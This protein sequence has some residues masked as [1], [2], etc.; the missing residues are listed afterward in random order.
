MEQVSLSLAEGDTFLDRYR[1]ERVLG[2]GGM[3]KVY[4]ASDLMLS[5]FKIALKTLHS[6]LCREPK[7]KQRFLREVQLN[8]MLNHPNV[9]KIFDIGHIGDALY[10]TMEFVKGKTLKERLQESKLSVQEIVSILKEICKGLIAVHN[11]NIIHRDLKPGN[12]L[13]SDSG[14]VKIADFGVARPGV[15][16]LTAHDE[17]IGCAPYIA[18]EV[19]IGRNVSAAADIY[20]LG[21]MAYEMLVGEL[22]FDGDSPAD[23]MR[24]HLES[25][26]Y[27]LREIDP[28]TPEWLENLTLM[29][30][31]KD[32]SKRP[33]SAKEILDTL[34]SG[35]A[36]IENSNHRREPSTGS[37]DEDLLRH[38]RQAEAAV[39]LESEEQIAPSTP[40]ERRAR[41]LPDWEGEKKR[42]IAPPE[43][44]SP[45][46]ESAL[47][48][49]KLF[50]V[51]RADNF[52]TKV[53]TRSGSYDQ[54]NDR[55]AP[56]DNR[57]F[58]SA[59]RY[60]LLFAV[61]IVSVVLV[62]ALTADYATKLIS[63]IAQPFP[64]GFSLVLTSILESLLITPL[65]AAP[66]T[67]VSCLSN[68]KTKL[69]RAF[70][71]GWPRS[72]SYLLMP[73]AFLWIWFVL[74]VVFID[75]ANVSL[76]PRGVPTI[77]SAVIVNM[78][79]IA[80]LQP[81]GTF[82]RVM[83]ESTAAG[84][85]V[86]HM[87]LLSAVPYYT[88][89]GLAIFGLIEVLTKDLSDSEIPS[90]LTFSIVSS[91]IVIGSL[92]NY[93]LFPVLELVDLPPNNALSFSIGREIVSISNMQITLGL[94]NYA[95]IILISRKLLRN[96]K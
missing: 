90:T 52:V 19:W 83:G 87:T 13:L 89:L 36:T 15:S 64:N 39:S 88:A 54:Q 56:Y 75:P 80:L 45:A 47:L 7:H 50:K 35:P 17:I 46:A 48:S 41:S 72:V 66:L 26:P 37:L 1:I 44:H 42:H 71:K 85:T 23:L 21:V 14:E 32:P 8:R 95:S 63:V 31:E 57:I 40:S 62:Q 22:P 67:L 79:E 96:R 10:L 68:A 73:A 11:E 18:P 4:L 53:G 58:Y 92:G 51:E 93:L 12:V 94:I 60:G 33:A 49:T 43:Q 24:K 34:I 74:R 77:T 65:A 61:V 69:N 6:E 9:V 3:G 20:A 16:E 38:L 29:M 82:Y 55:S 81:M 28:E 30:L 25:K 86:S 27:P 70:F 2:S 5:D 78:L 91:I 84:V 76:L 59:A